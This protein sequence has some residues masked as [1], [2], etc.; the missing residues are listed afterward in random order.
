MDHVD[1]LLKLKDLLKD[2]CGKQAISRLIQLPLIVDYLNDPNNFQ[3]VVD[4]FGKDCQNWNPINICSAASGFDLK[5][6]SL[7]S[8]QI[9]VDSEI[10]AFRSSI[11]PQSIEKI[12]SIVEIYPLA[13]KI[14]S[15]SKWLPWSQILEQIGFGSYSFTD[16][17]R[18]LETIFIIVFEI[19]EDK[20]KFIDGLT[21]YQVANAGQKLLSRLMLNNKSVSDFVIHALETKSFK[22]SSNEFVSLLKEMRFLGDQEISAKTGRNL[23]GMFTHLM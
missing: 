12:N 7:I 16:Q 2:T 3:L 5:S 4:K 10:E 15:L 22:P 11:S 14:N 21:E 20:K 23:S 19:S 18:K 13:D 1:I 17:K 6:P 9:Q 8:S